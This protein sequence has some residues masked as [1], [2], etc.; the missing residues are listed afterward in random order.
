MDGLFMLFPLLLLVV[1]MFFMSR[2][3]R[4]TMQA[5]MAFRSEL[6]PG[7][8]VM[9][10]SGLFGT[11]V[12]IDE[13]TDR[14]TIQSGSSTSVWLRAA[15]SKRTDVDATGAPIATP[16]STSSTETAAGD[17]LAALD[18]AAREYQRAK[19]EAASR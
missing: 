7:Q 15:I 2:R 11:I 14:I 13:A 19:D 10:G 3:Q 6:A 16:S 4:K 8:E 17:D 18:T 1:F 12:E 9:T 5:Q